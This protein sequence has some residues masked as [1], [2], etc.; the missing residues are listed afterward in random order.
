MGCWRSRQSMKLLT[1]P[2]L[3]FVDQSA[4]ETLFSKH[5]WVNLCSRQCR[6]RSVV[7]GCRWAA[8]GFSNCSYQLI[9]KLQ[10]SDALMWM[11]RSNF[12]HFASCNSFKRELIRQIFDAKHNQLQ[13]FSKSS[14]FALIITT[15]IILLIQ[16][17]GGSKGI[18]V[19]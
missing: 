1:A 8:P 19:E 10:D 5:S 12:L 2:L 14:L 13:F 17:C 7:R 3:T 16:R 15:W 18:V 11:I 9:F 6:S 4:V